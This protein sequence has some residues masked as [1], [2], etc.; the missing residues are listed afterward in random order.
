MEAQRGTG[1]SEKDAKL[2]LSLRHHP[3]PDLQG[4]LERE[5][6]L[7]ALPPGQG[8]GP[9]HCQRLPK[10]CPRG[11]DSSQTVQTF[12]ALGQRTSSRPRAVCRSE[13]RA[14]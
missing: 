13:A 8:M 11:D 7:F 12:W 1:Q 6:H 4:A 3:N 10:G 9:S 2:R 5:L 14:R